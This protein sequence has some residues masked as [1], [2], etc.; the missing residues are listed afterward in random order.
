[1]VTDLFGSL[2]QELSPILKVKDLHPDQNNSCLIRLKNGIK[3]QLEIDL[4]GQFLLIGC[5]L[6]DLPRGRYRENILREALKANDMPPPL[7]GILAFSEKTQHLIL[8]TKTPATKTSGEKIAAEIA[9]FVEKAAIWIDALKRGEIPVITQP[10]PS[11]S[12]MFG[13]RP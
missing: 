10:L 12:A 6:G 8:F 9:P 2:L 13:M 7:H 11:G 1:M 4:S 5:N 3:I